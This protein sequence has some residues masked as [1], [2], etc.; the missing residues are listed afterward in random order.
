MEDHTKSREN[1]E[2]TELNEDAGSQECFSGRQFRGRGIRV[3][4]TRATV[5][6][7]N[8]HDHV[9]TEE[10]RDHAARVDWR[11]IRHVV[12]GAAQKEV[13]GQLVD[14]AAMTKRRSAT[15]YI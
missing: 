3:G 14:R 5:S 4:D 12:K 15:P 10:G 6:R 7:Q 8:A 1:A 11:K 9:E 13:T 2:A